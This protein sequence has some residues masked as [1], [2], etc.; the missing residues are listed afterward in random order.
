M[1][2]VTFATLLSCYIYTNYKI[3]YLILLSN[4]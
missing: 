1:I 2:Y 3:I 4:N